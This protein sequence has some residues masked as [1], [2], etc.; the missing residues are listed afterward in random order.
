MSVKSR[1]RELDAN[2][3]SQEK[4]EIKKK[5][6]KKKTALIIVFSILA[7]IAIFIGI[8][9]FGAR[10]AMKSMMGG[11]V[12]LEEVSR[13]ELISDVTIS[14]N[15]ESEKTIHYTAPDAILIDD[16]K[17]N[18]S[19]VKKGEPILL[20][21]EDSYNTSLRLALLKSQSAESTYEGTVA[22]NKDNENRYYEAA[23]RFKKYSQLVN[24]Q[25]AVV[26]QLAKDITDA[27]AHWTAAL[28]TQ[29]S[30]SNQEL[31][32]YQFKNKEMYSKVTA[33]MYTPTAEETEWL[34]NYEDYVY[35][36]Q[37]EISNIS[38]QIQ[39]QS[40]SAAAYDNQKK[41]SEANALLAEYKAEKAAAESEMKS[42]KATIASEYDK[43]SL[44]I[45]EE[46]QS[47]QNENYY[48]SIEMFAEGLI[49]PFDGVVT[50][51]GYTKDDTTV[52]GTPLVTFSSLDDVHVTIGVT[53]TDLEHLKEGQK[54]KIKILG[55]TYNGE[56]KTIN[57]MVTQTGNS[58]L[59]MVTVSIDD[60]DDNI[61]LGIDA[62][63]TIT[64]AT[65]ADCIRIPVE[66]VNVDNTGEFVY[67]M[68]P[69]TMIV[70]KKYVETGVSGDFYIEIKSGL[71]EG[72]I[73]ISTYTGTITEGMPAMVSPESMSLIS[74]GN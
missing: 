22:K 10:K 40:S 67:T 8:I 17:G 62:K 73:I 65:L 16:I 54:A 71:E 28:N 53:K 68:D 44:E 13:G 9:I 42:Y 57:H 52:A 74:A 56:V 55:N 15:V 69:A 58:S 30:I 27:S 70:G 23:G 59:V 4:L 31:S 32:D 24:D 33:F 35:K 20:F 37:A 48:D 2:L 5:K 19:F 7:V 25:Q 47:I 38:R 3:S 64:L 11:T 46:M 26:D 34:K 72:D 50:S 41:V 12:T 18:G 61:Y 63:C 6:R 49:A 66:S 36:K 39:E 14:G 45:S 51:V 21:N 43:K 29:L 1:K 60:P